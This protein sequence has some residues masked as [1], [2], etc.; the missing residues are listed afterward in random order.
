V[1]EPSSA[2]GRE[3][4]DGSFRD[5]QYRAYRE[6][7]SAKANTQHNLI[8]LHPA[9]VQHRKPPK[10]LVF[11]EVVFTGKPFMRNVTVINF[12]WVGHLLP[13]LR[14]NIHILI[15]MIYR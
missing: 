2:R 4:S 11:S 15:N 8:Y 6:I 3:A 14:Y 10:W 9:S 5:A 13:R 7:V 12:D 1:A